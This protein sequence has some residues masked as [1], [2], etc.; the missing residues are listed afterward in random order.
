MKTSF[1]QYPVTLFAFL[2]LLCIS[3]NK[4][5][6][7][8][9]HDMVFGLGISPN[10][11]TD[12]TLFLSTDAEATS[13]Q[14][15]NILR[16]SDGG[17]TWIR[18][19]NG[20]DNVF[21]DISIRVSP[22]Y[23]TDNTVF[24][25][26]KGDG[27]YQSVDQGNS[28]QLSNTGLFNLK[29]KELTIAKL[30]NNDYVVFLTTMNG[31]L[32][33]RSRTETTWT[34]LQNSTLG[35]QL[36]A[37]SP[38]FTTD[39]TAITV[40]KTG[41]LQKST[42]G[43]FTWNSIG[44]IAGTTFHDI[45]MSGGN[46]KEVFLATADGIYYSDNTGA[47]FTLKPANLPLE[48]INNVSL[49]PNY[50]TD[51]TVFCTSLTKA[52]YKSTDGGDSWTYHASGAAVTGQT[53]ALEEFSELQVSNTFSADQ[54][55]FL[56]AYD[57]LFISKDGGITWAQKQTRR[58]LL[59]GVALSPNFINDQSVIATTYF[60]GGIYTSTDRGATWTMDRTG[61]PV[62]NSLSLPMSAFDV[63][64]SQNQSGS[65]TAVASRNT[66]HIGFS[67]D[68]GQ[69]WTTKFIPK[70]TEISPFAVYINA[71]VLSPTFETDREIYLGTRSH[72]ILQTLDGGNSW[73][74]LRGVPTTSHIVSLA[75][76]P[77]YANDRTAFTANRSGEVWRTTDGGNS[78]LQSRNF[79]AI[80]LRGLPGQQH[81]SIAVSPQF[82][83]DKLV[84]IGTSNGL[85]RSKNGGNVWT[86]M[87]QNHIGP[88][89]AIHQV[90]FSPNFSNDRL[91]FVNVH[92]KGLYKIKLNNKGNIATSKNIGTSL[93]QENI[94]FTEF[95][96]S[97]GFALDATI[98]G[99]ARDSTYI[100]NDGGL[101]WTLAGKVEW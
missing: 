26:T 67:N 89:N 97:P 53:A 84:F 29:V 82:A 59:T 70:I 87:T 55:V 32:Y 62:P 44:N 88:G 96:L 39:L 43:G 11:A 50:L 10:Y 48:A 64:F 65:P 27:V 90:E 73:R 76:S 33:R 14:Y 74:W 30:G 68:F 2:I 47:T 37:V 28:W 66:G 35:I 1:F 56:S 5:H 34:R 86:T 100:S 94:Q 20:L 95:R 12:K 60:G 21:A 46:P 91:I 93:L 51:R 78:W 98:L 72:G 16:S 83:A 71:F 57:G 22:N 3:S 81:L 99:V 77:N 54:T 75:I 7:H 85:Y 80:T 63:N 61:W 17:A 58:N 41:N 23:G 40:N 101:T 45:A 8:N 92:G 49:S 36:V 25:T 15:T 4:I 38:S 42:D 9:P 18:L 6:A 24:A 52:V 79:D 31:Q 19:P 13:D 69:N